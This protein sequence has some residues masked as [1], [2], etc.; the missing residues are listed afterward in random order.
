[1]EA[2]DLKSVRAD[3]DEYQGPVPQEERRYGRS[4]VAATSVEGRVR[5]GQREVMWARL[6]G[7]ELCRIARR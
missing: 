4:M 2:K 1:M 7:Q 5:P 6:S 3:L